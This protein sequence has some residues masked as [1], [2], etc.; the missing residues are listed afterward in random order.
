VAEDFKEKIIEMRFFLS[1]FPSPISVYLTR[2]G[3]E[4]NE[5][6]VVINV[7]VMGLWDVLVFSKALVPVYQN[8]RCHTPEI[9]DLSKRSVQE[10][11]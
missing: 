4:G 11:S 3:V 8:A 10:T 6:L 1:F 9:H 7:K 2:L 5:V